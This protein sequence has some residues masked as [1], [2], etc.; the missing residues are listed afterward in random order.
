MALLLPPLGAPSCPIP[1][2]GNIV[3]VLFWGQSNAH[4][5]GDGIT[6]S[7]NLSATP[8]YCRALDEHL[9]EAGYFQ[10]MG[11][12]CR[13]QAVP[14]AL[15]GA[16]GSLQKKR[17][18]A[19]QMATDLL[20]GARVPIV[21]SIARSGTP[22][23]DFGPG[24]YGE[25]AFDTYATELTNQLGATGWHIVTLHGESDA[26]TAPL[27]AAY[28]AALTSWHAH[29][30]TKFTGARIYACQLNTAFTGSF[31]ATVQAAITA[32]VGG[33]GNAELQNCDAFGYASPH[34]TDAGYNSIGSLLST[35]IIANS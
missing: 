3:K 34:Y 25:T 8:Y 5:Q 21:A 12:W 32:V 10:R 33:D 27:S 6:Y 18:A 23:A 15:V 35:R 24:Q 2:A 11:G 29:M 7:A 19:V 14:T 4:G 22:I 28:Q 9:R 30:R 20:A 16:L 26:G 13:N 31:T 17:G 1:T